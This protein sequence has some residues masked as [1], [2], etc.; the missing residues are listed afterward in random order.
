MTDYASAASAERD[1]LSAL[2]ADWNCSDYFSD[3]QIAGMVRERQS[4]GTERHR[5]LSTVLALRRKLSGKDRA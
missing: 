4:F 3:D 2:T 5:F 1:A